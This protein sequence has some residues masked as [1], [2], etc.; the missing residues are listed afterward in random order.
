MDA[1]YLS[2]SNKHQKMVPHVIKSSKYNLGTLSPEIK[3]QS[4]ES[5][6]VNFD[7]PF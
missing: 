5:V 4:I 2:V 7:P 6:K 3:G 1:H